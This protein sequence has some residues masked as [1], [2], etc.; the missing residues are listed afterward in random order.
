[1]AGRICLRVTEQGDVN[2]GCGLRSATTQRSKSWSEAYSKGSVSSGTGDPPEP[3]GRRAASFILSSQSSNHRMQPRLVAYAGLEALDGLPPCSRDPVHHVTDSM[4]N[5][6]GP[7]ELVSSTIPGRLVR[8]PVREPVQEPPED[9]LMCLDRLCLSGGEPNARQEDYRTSARQEDYRTAPPQG[10]GSSMDDAGRCQASVQSR[11]KRAADPE[12]LSGVGTVGITDGG[13]LGTGRGFAMSSRW[14]MSKWRARL[15]TLSEGARGSSPTRGLS[16]ECAP[17]VVLQDPQAGPERSARSDEASSLLVIAERGNGFSL[18][19]EVAQRFL[20]SGD[21]ESRGQ[22]FDPSHI[23]RHTD[24]T[25][26]GLQ[27]QEA[28]QRSWERTDSGRRVR[29]AAGGGP[30]LVPIVLRLPPEDH[31][32]LVEEWYARL[33]V[34]LRLCS[35]P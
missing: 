16:P 17:P 35:S 28:Q 11:T 8:E 22:G 15:P 6:E 33:R 4:P 14:H 1:M 18:P 12:E 23:D 2:T 5:P 27:A 10:S 9:Q 29:G 3:V 13:S 7:A 26:A 24:S 19:G 31:G 20:L 30:V 34:R 32:L 25:F 21:S